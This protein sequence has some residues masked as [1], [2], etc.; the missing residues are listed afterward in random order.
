MAL[1]ITEGQSFTY[2]ASLQSADS[3][4]ISADQLTSITLTYYDRDTGVV[5]N[6]WSSKTVLSTNGVTISATGGLTWEGTTADAIL[7]NRTLPPGAYE[8]HKGL[9]KWIWGTTEK[10][11]Y[12]EATFYVT[13][14]DKVI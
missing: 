14:R 5:I 1:S 3:T 2:S 9:F 11:G 6:A 12:H 8:V 13:Q 10:T 4:G 7:L